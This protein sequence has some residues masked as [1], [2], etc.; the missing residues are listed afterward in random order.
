MLRIPTEKLICALPAQRDRHV[1]S[2]N[3]ADDVESKRGKIRDGLV[4]VSHERGKVERFVLDRKPH[5]VMVT[6]EELS[7]IS[8]IVEFVGSVFLEP[9]RERLYWLGHVTTHQRHDETRVEPAGEHRSHRYVAH[10][11]IPDRRLE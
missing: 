4:H 2:G 3:T 11:P 8:R 1:F 9:D 7:N 10:E 5:F 6:T